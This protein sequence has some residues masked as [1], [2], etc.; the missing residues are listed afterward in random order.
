M[1][2]KDERVEKEL[3][4]K[5]RDKI[6]AM[7]KEEA[8]DLINYA[9]VQLFFDGIVIEISG[10]T[11]KVNLPSATTDFISNYTGKTLSV[12]NKVRVF[13]DTDTLSG[14]YIGIQLDTYIAP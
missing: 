9:N 8:V 5:F 11:A 6:R 2:D 1:L 12:G 13:A 4:D 3:L 7:I 14:A 10:E